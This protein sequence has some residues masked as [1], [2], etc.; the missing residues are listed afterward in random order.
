[1]RRVRLLSW[2]AVSAIA[3]AAC[4]GDEDLTSVEQV[5]YGQALLPSEAD[6]VRQVPGFGGFF[7]DAN[8]TP[9]VYLVPG[10]SRSPADRMLAGYLKA[11][12]L[13]P[14][15]ARVLEGRYHWQE[16]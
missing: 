3:L 14:T 12:G 1:M 8:G 13:A 10:T 2:F 11:R 5:S 6:F 7:L 4:G 9:T 16:L 15:G